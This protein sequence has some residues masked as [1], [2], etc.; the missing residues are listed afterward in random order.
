MSINDC[1]A[2]FPVSLYSGSSSRMDHG[3]VAYCVVHSISLCLAVLSFFLCPSL[4][5]ILSL[6]LILLHENNRASFSTGKIIQLQTSPWFFHALH[7]AFLSMFPCHHLIL[8]LKCTHCFFL[9]ARDFFSLS[10]PWLVTGKICRKC[11][12]I[13]KLVIYH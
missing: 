3:H 13:F 2:I 11:H 9:Y 8:L 12:T 5:V 1:A 6:S 7:S 4:S 10:K